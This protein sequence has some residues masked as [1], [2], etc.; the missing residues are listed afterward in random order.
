MA[1]VLWNDQ[2]LLVDI[3]ANMLLFPFFF[4]FNLMSVCYMN[5]EYKRN[6]YNSYL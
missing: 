3:Y 2:R 5:Y 4:S 6:T 1:T